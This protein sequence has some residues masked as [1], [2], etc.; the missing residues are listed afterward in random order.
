MF[1]IKRRFQR[2]KAWSPTFRESSIRA[3]Q[4]WVPPWKRAISATVD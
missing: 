1:C 3:H 2:C 4:I